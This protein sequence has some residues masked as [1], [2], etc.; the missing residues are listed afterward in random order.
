MKKLVVAIDGPA[1]SGKSTVSKLVAKRLGL[2][3]LDTGA[4]YRAL[5]LKAMREGINFN[6]EE[7]V[8]KLAGE[9]EITLTMEPGREAKVFLDGDDVTYEIRMPEVTQNVKHVACIPAVRK[10]MVELQR[11]IAE[12]EGAV[13]E[14]RDIGTVVLK[15]APHKFY[16]DASEKERVTRRL[17]E[18]LAKGMDVDIKDIEA[19]VKARDTSDTNRKVG[20]LKKADDAVYVDT[21]RLSIDE[22]VDKIL[23]YINN[24]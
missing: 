19:D 22:V 4:M 2:L 20:P 5:T 6:N 3:Y 24:K 17:K 10:R 12:S 21:T 11:N 7:A 9:A 15:D 23:S 16:L 13:V 1:G 18:L 8:I 14:G